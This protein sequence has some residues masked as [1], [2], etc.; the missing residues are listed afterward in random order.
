MTSTEKLERARKLEAEA[1]AIRR[2]EKEF[3]QQVDERKKEILEHWQKQKESQSHIKP[4]EAAPHGEW[5]PDGAQAEEPKP[6]L[7]S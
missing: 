1:K 2:E 3:W 5:A 4:S 6:W 7:R